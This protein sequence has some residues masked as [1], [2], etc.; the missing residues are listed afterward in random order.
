MYIVQVMIGSIPP[1]ARLEHLVRCFS[2]CGGLLE[3]RL[4]MIPQLDKNRG[5]GYMTFRDPEGAAAARRVI[6]FH[7]LFYLIFFFE[8]FFLLD[9]R[10][11]ETGIV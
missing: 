7:L 1:T 9:G 6:T 2:G 8:Q 3:V 5:Y 11:L 4:V 10:S